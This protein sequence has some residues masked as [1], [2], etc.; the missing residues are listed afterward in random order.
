MWKWECKKEF[1]SKVREI[2]NKYQYYDMNEY[3]ICKTCII[4]DVFTKLPMSCVIWWN[5]S[6]SDYK[7]QSLQ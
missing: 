7:L 5:I 4:C 1:I 6:D 2:I 3:F